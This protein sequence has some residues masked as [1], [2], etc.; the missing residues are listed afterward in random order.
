MLWEKAAQAWVC[1]HLREGSGPHPGE[2]HAPRVSVDVSRDVNFL[3]IPFPAT[4]PFLLWPF[5]A[6]SRTDRLDT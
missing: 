6:L 2:P 4:P 1:A 5:W 3:Y